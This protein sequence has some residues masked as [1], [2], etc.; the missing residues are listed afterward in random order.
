MKLPNWMT[1]GKTYQFPAS[2]KDST[3]HKTYTILE[4]EKNL[5]RN[6][7]VTVTKFSRTYTKAEQISMSLVQKA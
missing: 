1:K 2:H 3:I 4:S 6:S 7:H 5:S